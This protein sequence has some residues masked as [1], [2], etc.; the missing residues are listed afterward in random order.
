LRV[1]PKLHCGPKYK[2]DP[3]KGESKKKVFFK[4]LAES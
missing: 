4:G 2:P 3:V 1:A